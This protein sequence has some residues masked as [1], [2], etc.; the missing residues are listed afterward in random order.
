MEQGE[1]QQDWIINLDDDRQAD[2]KGLAAERNLGLDDVQPNVGVRNERYSWKDLI[3]GEV[4]DNTCSKYSGI[5][6]GG[7]NTISLRLMTKQFPITF[8]SSMLG[9]VSAGTL[10]ELLSAL[11]SDYVLKIK[12]NKRKNAEK[13]K[14]AKAEKEKKKNERPAEK[15][16]SKK[17]RAS[18][19]KVF[20][21]AQQSL[22]P[23]D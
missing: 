15:A 6:H 1:R 12:D 20:G 13:L 23:A 17:R 16:K 19:E 14:A 3:Y 21:A 11:Y 22:S 7:W 2:W 8:T 4:A 18:V 5:G 9:S 10:E